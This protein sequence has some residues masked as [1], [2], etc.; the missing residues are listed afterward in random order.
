MKTLNSKHPTSDPRLT[1]K[2]FL[3]FHTFKL[4]TYKGAHKVKVKLDAVST[5]Y[6]KATLHTYCFFEKS[7]IPKKVRLKKK[8]AKTTA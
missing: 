2:D 6:I 1:F 8:T 5:L 3:N 4:Y 7:S